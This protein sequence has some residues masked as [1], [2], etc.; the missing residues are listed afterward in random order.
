V[1]VDTTQAELVDPFAKILISSY[2]A[3]AADARSF[4]DE[5]RS[6]PTKMDR[7]HR[8][9]SIVQAQVNQSE[10]FSLQPEYME[11]GRVQVTDRDARLGYLIRSKA[12]IDIDEITS[13]PQQLVLFENLRP[14]VTGYP[15]MLAYNFDRNGLRLWICPTKQESEERRRLVPAG[16]LDLIGYWRYDAATPPDGGGD[17]FDQGAAD[18]WPDLGDPDI[19]DVGEADGL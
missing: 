9:R 18:P 7:V 4:T 2:L 14:I 11:A 17:V 1:V 16:D 8:F 3:A 5:W 19:D 12:M 15:D 6:P 10:R 13:R